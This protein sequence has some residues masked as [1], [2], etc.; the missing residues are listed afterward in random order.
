MVV[1]LTSDANLHDSN[2]VDLTRDNSS[3]SSFDTNPVIVVMIC[4]S[5][6]YYNK[7]NGL[8][9]GVTYS[10]VHR[11]KKIIWVIGVLRSSG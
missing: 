4:C 10:T 9:P 2:V 1:D 6:Y 5:F 11:L 7:K 8:N 3:D